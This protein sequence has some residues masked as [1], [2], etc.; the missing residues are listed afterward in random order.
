MGIWLRM[1]V[2]MMHIVSLYY[3]FNE[4]ILFLILRL[5]IILGAKVVID[6]PFILQNKKKS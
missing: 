2:D 3:D 5:I 1:N 6:Q 4:M